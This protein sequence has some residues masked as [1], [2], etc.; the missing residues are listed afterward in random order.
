MWREY[1]AKCMEDPKFVTEYWLALAREQKAT[2]RQL[3]SPFRLFWRLYY[4]VN[5]E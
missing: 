1:L 5:P 3:R 2:D 4:A